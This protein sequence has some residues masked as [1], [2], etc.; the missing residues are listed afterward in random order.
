MEIVLI[1][2]DEEHTL[3]FLECLVSAHPLVDK[4]IGV[5]N[6]T[7][8]IQKARDEKP[9][10]AFLD[11][12]LA[13]EDHLNGIQTAE[14]IA[15]FSS[16]TKLVFV[17]GHSDY[18]IESFSAHPYDFIMKPI[19]KN[20][21]LNIITKLLTQASTQSPS[22]KVRFRSENSTIFVDEDHIH[23]IE[24]KGKTISIYCKETVYSFQGCLSDLES[25]LPKQFIRCHKSY[26]VNINNIVRI[27]PV[28][29]RSY[30]VHFHDYKETAWISRSKYDQHK[31]LFSS[32]Y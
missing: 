3:Q 10:I 28:G 17:T 8:A 24:K 22:K 12:E 5:S 15:T 30:A 16:E 7:D 31:H 18:A 1:L 25:R 26:I 27:T 23:F 21:L 6:S 4:V 19:N 13:A 2:E 20:K 29:N 11:I 32:N 14:F 9:S